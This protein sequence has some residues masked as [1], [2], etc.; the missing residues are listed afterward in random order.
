VNGRWEIFVRDQGIGIDSRH[1]DRIFRM[2]ERLHSR[3]EYPGTGIGLAICKKIIERHGG[4]IWVDSRPGCG[5]TF[6][7]TLPAASE[8][9]RPAAVPPAP[10]PAVG[11]R[12][13]S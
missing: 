4:R 7:F 8:N 6:F 1:F 9:T 3:E 11:Q 12:P 2:F 13:E 10:S 5:A